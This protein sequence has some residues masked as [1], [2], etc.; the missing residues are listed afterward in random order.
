MTNCL[1]FSYWPCSYRY[2]ERSCTWMTFSRFFLIS[3]APCKFSAGPCIPGQSCSLI[4]QIR[5]V[6]LC[7]LFII[8]ETRWICTRFL[9][10]PLFRY[11]P[12]ICSLA[13]LNPGFD[14]HC[15]MNQLINACFALSI[16]FIL[17]VF[18]GLCHASID[19]IMSF[20]IKVK[21]T[22]LAQMS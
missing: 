10:T 21:N 17:I 6:T 18:L 4:P 9:T 2:L 20:M 5:L 22:N 3:R 12:M 8:Q 16:L 14:E 15:V 7:S 11:A 19:L 13:S 1:L